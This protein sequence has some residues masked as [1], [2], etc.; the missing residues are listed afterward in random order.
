MTHIVARP[1]EGLIKMKTT[2]WKVAVLAIAVAVG[3][4]SRKAYATTGNPLDATITVTP[5][6][7]VNLSLGVTTYAF[8]S[9]PVSSN[10]VAVSS[11]AIINI[12]QVNVSMDSKIQTE[13]SNW[14]SDTTTGVMNHYVLW[15]ATSATQ[16][17]YT[18]YAAG[19]MFNA[20]GGAVKPLLG[21]GG[22]SPVLTTSGAGSE[23]DLWFRLDTPTSVSSLAGQTITVRFT[24]TGQ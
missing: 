21:I 5:T 12:G 22:G 11:L 13:A 9:I 7:T 16:P 6:A 14:I 17:V 8:G 10:A 1:K 18:Q 19:H 15:V 24:G 3:I 20:F 23:A 4:G 2:K